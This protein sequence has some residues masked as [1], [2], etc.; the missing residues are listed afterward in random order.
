MHKTIRGVDGVARTR[1]AFTSDRAATRMAG[2]QT[3]SAGAG[4]EIY[5][6]DYDGANPRR[7]TINRTMNLE[8]R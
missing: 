2:R 8:A 3:G 5:L 6:M 1:L 4:K 7:I